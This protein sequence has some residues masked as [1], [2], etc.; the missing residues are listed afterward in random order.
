[1]LTNLKSRGIMLPGLSA[2]DNIETQKNRFIENG[3]KGANVWTVLE[4]YRHHLSA[5]EVKR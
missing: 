5:E 3:F 2:C 1:M 4:I